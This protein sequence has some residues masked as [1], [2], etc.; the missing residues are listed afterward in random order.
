M[1]K[2]IF[3]HLLNDFSGSPKVLSQIIQAVQKKGMALELYTGKSE[4]GFL[5]GLTQNHHQYFYKRSEHKWLTLVTFLSSQLILFF[6]LLKYINKDVV[7]YVNTM[8]PFGAALAGFVMR[9]P[10]IYHVHEISLTPLALKHFL[11]GVIRLTAQKIIFVSNAV[12]SS[13]QFLEKKEY[14]VYNALS[15]AFVNNALNQ[16]NI[17]TKDP[18]NVL[19]LASLKAYKGLQEFVEIATLLEPNKHIS[20]TLIINATHKEVDI[21]FRN[22]NLTKNIKIYSSQSDVIPFYHKASLVLNLSHVDAW[23]ETFGLTIVEAMAFGIPVIVPPVGGP[24]EIVTDGVE[25]YLISSHD[26]NNI[27]K[28]IKDLSL[29]TDIWSRLSENALLRSKYFNQETFEKEIINVL[30]A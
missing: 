6:K 29:N 22:K 2:Y 18:F 26:T 1:K 3:V 4:S 27:A 16:N 17:K 5:S 23:V 10:V 13:E 19:M 12:R 20:F 21:Y 14:V 9:K 11:R 25:G 7:F 15:N 28:K 24:T 30:N 8:L